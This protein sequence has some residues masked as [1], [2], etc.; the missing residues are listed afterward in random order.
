M[1]VMRIVAAHI[2]DKIRSHS[3][4]WSWLPLTSVPSAAV[5]DADTSEWSAESYE[6]DLRQADKP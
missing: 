6:L 5:S 3:C 4:H 1:G 2:L